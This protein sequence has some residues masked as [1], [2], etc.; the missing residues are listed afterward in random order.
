LPETER[1][2]WETPSNT[3]QD[4]SSDSRGCAFGPSSDVNPDASIQR[5]ARL[6]RCVE[7]GRER[8]R[9]PG[10]VFRAVL[11]RCS[12]AVRLC[13]RSDDRKT[14][15][16][17]L[18]GR[19]F[20][21]AVHERLEGAGEDLRIEGSPRKERRRSSR[22][23]EVEIAGNEDLERGSGQD[24]PRDRSSRSAVRALA[25]RR[26]DWPPT[27]GARR[28]GMATRRPGCWAPLRTT[29]LARHWLSAALRR[30][31]DRQRETFRLPGRRHGSSS[32]AAQADPGAGA[33]RSRAG[34]GRKRRSCVRRRERSTRTPGDHGPD[35]RSIRHS[36]RTPADQ[37]PRSTPHPCNSRTRGW[38]PPQGDVGTPRTRLDCHHAGHVLARDPGPSGRGCS[39]N[40]CPF[41]HRSSTRLS[42]ARDRKTS[43]RAMPGR[44]AREQTGSTL[45]ILS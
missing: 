10:A 8:Q 11:D 5:A 34:A 25:G 7:G 13:D 9:D 45:P 21:R 43:T 30:A 42:A 23:T 27:R 40:G 37:V 31:Q 1:H 19:P 29:D 17:A 24:V 12:A 20:V 32:Q 26:D 36:L 22:P 2:G 28:F 4:R 41:S 33:T 44:A 6:S 3:P 35:V 14:E 39:A 38:G 18:I 15:P 16:R